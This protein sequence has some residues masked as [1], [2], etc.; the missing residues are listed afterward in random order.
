[1]TWVLAAL[2]GLAFGS[3]LN[4]CIW[5]I[6]RRESIVNPPSHCPQCG[7]LI[8]TFDNIPVLSYVLLRGRCRDC[9]KPISLRYPL[10]EG[11][12]GVLFVAAYARFG[13]EWMTVKA[14]VLVCLLVA[15]AL[16]DL[17]HQVIPF[18]L[19]VSGLVLG[20]A[21]GFLP[22][23]TLGDAALGAVVG[24]G[25][26]GFAWLLWRYVLAGLFRR[27]GVNQ[28]EGMGGGDLPYAA[29]IGAFLGLRSTVVALFA[30]ILAGVII[31]LLLRALGRTR[32]G[33][34]IPFG[35]FLAV[36]ALVGLFFGRAIFDWYLALA[37]R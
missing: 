23:P 21:G 13:F 9:G 35:P 34:Q 27:F 12:T 16:I 8:R 37:L 10:V 32:R 24:G 7:R 31:G 36:G 20:L 18:R 3:F 26:I 19:S 4:V 6:P 2:L 33:Q 14:M 25:F 22:P 29:M 15:T 28:K 17:D 5:R 30:S 11:L 1:M